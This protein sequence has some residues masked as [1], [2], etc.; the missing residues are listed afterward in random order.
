MSLYQNV[1]VCTCRTAQLAKPLGSPQSPI[2]E[3][4]GTFAAPTPEECTVIRD[5]IQQIGVDISTLDSE[6]ERVETI[7]ERL[8]HKRSALQNLSN[9]H[10]NMLSPTRRLPVEILGEIFVQLQ[11][12]LGGRSIVPAQICRHWRE[13]AICTSRLWNCI[14]VSYNGGKLAA[15]EEM[16][17]L[18]L[19]RSGGQP[20][21]IMLGREAFYWGQSEWENPE[22]DA[23]VHG[24]ARR[25]KDVKLHVNDAMTSFLKKIP[26]D[27]PMLDTLYISG[28]PR[29]RVTPFTNFRNASALRIL[30]LNGRLSS[31]MPIFPWAQLTK[32]SLLR[33]GGY[34]SQD[35]YCV[36]SQAGNLRAYK[37]E[38]DA[39]TTNPDVRPPPGIC[40]DH[41]LSLDIDIFMGT[42]VR[43]LLDPLTLPALTDLRIVESFGND[44]PEYIAAM[45]TRSRCTLKQLS[46]GTRDTEFTHDQ[47]Y[48]IFKHTPVL[49]E[50][51][52]TFNGGA[53]LDKSLMDLMT[54]HPDHAAGPCC[55]LPQLTSIKLDVNSCLS[56]EELAEFLLMRVDATPCEPGAMAQLR[57]V[58][59]MLWDDTTASGRNAHHLPDET[60]EDFLGLRDNGLDLYILEGTSCRL[61]LEDYFIPGDEED[62]SEDEEEEYDDEDEEL[63]YDDV[64]DYDLWDL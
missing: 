38:L 32:C 11:E 17:S 24:Q 54:H 64:Y 35:G 40:L 15:D 39:S 3:L 44:L 30:T 53:G 51:E 49:A 50:L 5:R 4:L 9:G 28:R 58:A 6:I 7:L 27:L 62:D 22:F 16:V 8:R 41:L 29:D 23:A 59:L 18:W 33:E 46:I 14:K 12:M 61:E 31:P 10:H 34:T 21:N 13:V 47:L 19:Q 56:Y 1:E 26:E 20:L 57:T 52:L 63:E 60:Y 37:M 48:N 2:A 55:L 36:L 45:I 25:W 43:Y 42:D